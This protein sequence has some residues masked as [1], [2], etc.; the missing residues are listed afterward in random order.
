MTAYTALNPD[1]VPPSQVG[2]A[3]GIMGMI[4][5]FGVCRIDVRRAV[6]QV[7]L[8]RPRSQ[9]CTAMVLLGFVF[10][11]IAYAYPIYMGA[12]A[13]CAVLT[14]IAG[15]DALLSCWLRLVV[16]NTCVVP[17]LR[18]RTREKQEGDL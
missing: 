2:L 1:V 13:I 5:L 15:N 18:S 4:A 9:S 16:L 10:D 14:C 11:D 8:I 6:Q 17:L 3:S 12:T 7:D